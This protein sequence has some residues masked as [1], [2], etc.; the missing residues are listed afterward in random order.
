MALWSGLTINTTETAMVYNKLSSMNTIN[1]VRKMNSLAYKVL[2]KTEV[3]SNPNAKV[4][5]NKVK[6]V[7]GGKIEYRLRG[8]LYANLATVADGSAEYAAASPEWISDMEGNNEFITT[9]YSHQVA[10]PNHEVERF[11][12]K[13]AKTLDFI[14][15]RYDAE[16]LTIEK[17]L[18]TQINSTNNASRT[19]L[20]GWPW[21]VSDGVSTG[22]TGNIIYGLLDRSDAGNVDYRGYNIVSQGTLTTKALRLAQNSIRINGGNPTLGIAA[23][24]VYGILQMLLEGYQIVTN[25]AS[26]L[27]YGSDTFSYNGIEF[28]LDKYCPAA[29]L[30]LLTPSS[31]DFYMNKEG[32][33]TTG[34]M[35]APWLNSSHVIN[36][37]FWAG[38]FTKSPS[39][40]GKITGITG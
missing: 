38:F 28:M 21:A 20:S 1:I 10:I 35:D 6:N 4:N 19:Q 15:E 34:I 18:G 30:G 11:R 2:S 7:T 25:I 3:G 27:D 24:T 12:G 16:M 31:W 5:F 8:K 32:L 14:Q 9:H 36:T 37:E 22:E 23:A 26:S 39:W 40:N 17:E 29:V 13:E 33:T